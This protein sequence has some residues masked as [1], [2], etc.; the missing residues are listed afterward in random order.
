MGTGHEG[1]GTGLGLSHFALSLHGE[2]SLNRW[3]RSVD[4][5]DLLLPITPA[6]PPMGMAGAGTLPQAC[7]SADGLAKLVQ[8]N[9][10][11]NSIEGAR[12]G[13]TSKGIASGHSVLS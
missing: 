13:R 11:G 10:S 7:G 2:V 4:G 5:L 12:L 9:L 6:Q 8:F 3:M 1:Q